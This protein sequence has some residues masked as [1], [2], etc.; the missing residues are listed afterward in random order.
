MYGGLVLGGVLGVCGAVAFCCIR[1]KMRRVQ[2]TN[3]KYTPY[4][5]EDDDFDGIRSTEPDSAAD[6][7]VVA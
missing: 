3:R 2:V 5:V 6:G 7:L 4:G 1:R